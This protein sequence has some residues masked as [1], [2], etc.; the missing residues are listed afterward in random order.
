MVICSKIW[1]ILFLRNKALSKA[2]S[3]Q[4]FFA[5]LLVL[6]QDAQ[7]MLQRTQTQVFIF[8]KKWS[9]NIINFNVK[10]TYK[11]SRR[12]HKRKLGNFGLAKSFIS[13]IKVAINERSHS[14]SK[15]H[16]NLKLLSYEIIL[17]TEWKDEPLAVKTLHK[18]HTW[19]TTGI[20][21]IWELV[22]Q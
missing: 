3:E 8:L 20:Q 12:W 14:V 17:S 6:F 21:N 16:S 19:W 2:E 22:K 18:A 13:N 7:H 9:W 5:C 4:A 10:Q 15:C 11:A 1:N